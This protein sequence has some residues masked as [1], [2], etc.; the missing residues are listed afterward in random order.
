MKKDR[1]NILYI[2]SHDTGRYIHPYGYSMPTPNLQRLADE[3]VLFR[4]AFCAN[5]TCSPSRAALLTGQTAHSSG[6]LGLA[7]RGFAMADYSRHI[8]H[9]LRAHGY[10]SAL[11]GIQHIAATRGKAAEQ[12]IGYDTYLGNADV[13]EMAACQFL[14][15]RPEEPFFLSVGFK[16][17]HRPYPKEHALDHPGRIL[18]PVPL[19]DLPEIRED[20]ARLRASVRI[21]DDKMGQVLKALRRNRLAGRTLVICT[22]DHGIAFPG[23]KCCLTD[24]GIGVMLIMRGPAGFSA[25]KVV[26]GLV[27]HVDVFPTICDVLGIEHP[28]WLEGVSFLPLLDGKTAEVREEIFAELNYH[29]AYEPMRGVRTGRWKYIRRYDNRDKPV[30][31]NCDDG[32]SKSVWMEQGWEEIPPPSEVLYDLLFDPGETHNLVRS[33]AHHEVL[34]NMRG[35]LQRCMKDTADPLLDGPVA[36]PDGAQ[37]N[38][39]GGVS[40]NEKTGTVKG[41]HLVF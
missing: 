9:T 27:S 14:D 18:P 11:A 7:H 22:T 3:G 34:A 23:M 4:N 17:T 38:H 24:G 16:E 5:P 40:A 39:P 30:L 12:T 1:P 35:R 29:A 25:G 2:H 28:A 41:G 36:A 10:E 13:A 15:S 32:P 26:D 20:V 19:S 37:L 8:V 6:M 33:K 21:L 31:P